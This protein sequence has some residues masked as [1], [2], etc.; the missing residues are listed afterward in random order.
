LEDRRL[1]TPGLRERVIAVICEEAW[2]HPDNE[3]SSATIHR[4]LQRRGDNATVDEVQQVL[5]Q[6][7]DHHDITLVLNPTRGSGPV[8][9]DVDPELCP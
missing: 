3:V 1:T 2:P 8:V 4:R 6:L 9:A 7:S 5:F